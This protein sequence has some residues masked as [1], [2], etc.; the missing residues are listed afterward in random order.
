MLLLQSFIS[1]QNLSA[2]S[3]FIIFL[4]IELMFRRFK[5]RKAKE[6]KIKKESIESVEQI[7]NLSIEHNR[8]VQ[9]IDVIRFVIIFIGIMAILG[10]YNVQAFNILIVATGAFI[11]ILKEPFASLV[12]FF[13][14]LSNYKSG[15]N[16]QIDNFLGEILRVKPFYTDIAGKDE[17]GEYNGRLHC[18]PNYM[19]LSNIINQ[20]QLKSDDYNKISL[21]IYY[22]NK[23][24]KENFDVWLSKIENYLDSLL[25]RRSMSKVG[26]FKGYAGKKYKTD[27]DY[28]EKGEVVLKI[29][30]IARSHKSSKIKESIIL[31]VESLK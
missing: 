4:F 8:Q 20:Q 12:S 29:S 3:V 16:I 2:L 23:N 31:F 7:E 24:F 11:I 17:N 28:N 14:I 10:V 15:D 22:D 21:N 6:F 27:F 9:H 5:N 1:A 13:Y 18:I 25:P 26:H 30:F 19:F